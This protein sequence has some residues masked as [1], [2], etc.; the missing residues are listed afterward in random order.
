MEAVKGV[1]HKGMIELIEKPVSQ[2][3]AEVLV[4]FPQKGKKI[5]KI[6]GLFKK[7][8]IDYEAVEKELKKLSS[9]ISQS[10]AHRK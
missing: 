1:Y 7:Y 8:A 5:T 9:E 4:I 3:A 2:E 6:G 10:S